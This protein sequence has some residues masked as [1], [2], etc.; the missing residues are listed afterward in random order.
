MSEKVWRSD[1]KQRFLLNPV[2][3]PSPFSC[4]ADRTPSNCNRRQL[5]ANP[6][7]DEN[8]RD[9]TEPEATEMNLPTR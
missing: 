7:T 9:D 8:A 1:I 3:T 5:I 2:R 4:L 6:P